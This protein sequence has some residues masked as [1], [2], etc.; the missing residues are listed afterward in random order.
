MSQV[1]N[2]ELRKWP[3]IVKYKQFIVN[4]KHLLLNKL[5]ANKN[6]KHLY[7]C[8]LEAFEVLFDW[9]VVRNFVRDHLLKFLRN[10]TM[11]NENVAVT[12]IFFTTEMY[13]LV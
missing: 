10:V 11:K 4:Y 6:D 9:P 5:L 1:L 2:G 7:F 8:K 12:K 3:F 13:G